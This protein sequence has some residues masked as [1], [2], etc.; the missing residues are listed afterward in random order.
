MLPADENTWG[1]FV[2]HHSVIEIQINIHTRI[3][4]PIADFGAVDNL[5]LIKDFVN[6]SF[7]SRVK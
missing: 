5:S 6:K 3:L 4:D 7:C 2:T 1:I